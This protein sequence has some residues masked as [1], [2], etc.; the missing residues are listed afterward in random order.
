MDVFNEEYGNRYEKAR[1]ARL[2]AA[3]FGGRVKISD[4]NR[5]IFRIHDEIETR[6]YEE[7]I[8]CYDKV[9]E[10]EPDNFDILKRKA[11]I[12][13]KHLNSESAAII[14][15]NKI[16]KSAPNNIS[17]LIGKAYALKIADERGYKEDIVCLLAKALELDTKDIDCL[18]EIREALRFFKRYK[19][20]IICCDKILKLEPNN[21]ECLERKADVLY[22][23]GINE[24]AIDCCNKVLKSDTNNTN[25]LYTK[26]CALRNLRKYEEAIICLNKVLKDTN[27]HLRDSTESIIEQI[28]QPW[29]VQGLCSYC[30][31][32]FSGLF[33]KKCTVCGRAK[34]Y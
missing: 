30:G 13:R 29:Q 27:W 10:L 19:E 24:E 32:K 33:F 15:Y 4:S 1:S 3:A 21:S 26:G 5:E 18:K 9:L 17:C 34:D 31:G 14:C 11:D 25:C 28:Q 8:I 2:V 6:R 23:L 12:L 20:A 7:A 22:K 16:L